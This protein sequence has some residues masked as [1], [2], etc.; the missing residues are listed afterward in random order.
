LSRRK[1]LVF[2]K[3]GSIQKNNIDND[4]DENNVVISS[5]S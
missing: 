3:P 1:T 4:K 5:D 2:N